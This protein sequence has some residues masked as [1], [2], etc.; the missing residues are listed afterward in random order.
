MF[1]KNISCFLSLVSCLLFAGCTGQNNQWGNNY[2]NEPAGSPTELSGGFYGEYPMPSGG[3]V[4]NISVLL[5]NSSAG[6]SIKSAIELAV[7]QKNADDMNINFIELSG[8]SVQ[9]STIIQSALA[10]RP[11]MVIGPLFAED[12]QN[13]RNAKPFDLPVLSFTSD[14]AA[15][16]R[17][18]FTMS[19]L[20][21]QSVESIV[22]RM[23]SQGKKNIVILAPDTLSGQIMANA[24]IDSVSIYGARVAG[25]FYYTPGNM[26][27]MKT[28]AQ[29]AAMWDARSAA[30]TRAKEIL[31]DILIK[32]TIA[33]PERASVSAQLDTRNKADTLGDVPFDA[34]LFLSNADDSKT[35]G[36]FLR[37]FDLAPAKVKFYGTAMWDSDA[38][39][40]DFIF[41]DAEY[42]SLPAIPPEFSNMFSE[43]AG[44]APTR[45]STQGYDATLLAIAALRSSRGVADFLLAPS[46]FKGLD[47]LVRMQPNGIN[48]RALQ[49]MKLDASGT[50]KIMVGAATNFIKPLYKLEAQDSS[51]PQEIKIQGGVNPLDYITLPTGLV[52]QY[53]AKTYGN[54]T[55]TEP[56]ATVPTTDVETIPEDYSEPI[57]DSDFQPVELDKIDRT[58]IDETQMR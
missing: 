5:P 18:V 57:I 51:R 10:M 52:G 37:Y 16:G 14:V 48:E 27:N 19:L 42:S 35:L 53:T 24:A 30:N 2:G 36:S 56:A 54:T 26:D 46:G 39:F 25:F 23:S 12:A 29:K 31:S 20:P 40:S 32:K 34:V 11:D 17:G 49:I 41:T 3:P 44:G 28:T 4:K 8:N 21:I 55:P 43:F 9:K 22:Q 47:G 15:L 50:P 33:A 38:M 58:M 7:L 6:E 45:M 1:M 13:I